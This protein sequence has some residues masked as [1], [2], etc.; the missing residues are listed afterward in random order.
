M[1]EKML[2][3]KQTSGQT[4]VNENKKSYQ[5]NCDSSERHLSD[6]VGWVDAKSKPWTTQ[7]LIHNSSVAKSYLSRPSSAGKKKLTRKSR[8]EGDVSI[9]VGLEGERQMSRRLDNMII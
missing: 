4:Q 3:D 8:V 2:A 6:E 7:S 9:E 5:T 1:V